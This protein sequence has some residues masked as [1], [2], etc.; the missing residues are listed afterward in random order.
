MRAN[1]L[2]LWFACAAYGLLCA[3]RRIG[4][5]H[6]QFALA[7]PCCVELAGG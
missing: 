1:Q 2:R 7:Q 4:L 6:T 3:L 5:A